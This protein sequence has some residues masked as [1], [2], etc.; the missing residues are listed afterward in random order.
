MSKIVSV[1]MNKITLKKLDEISKGENR[2]RSGMIRN[3]V[4]RYWDRS[5]LTSNKS[6]QIN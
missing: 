5:K 3:L 1:W 2:T 4:I 6:K